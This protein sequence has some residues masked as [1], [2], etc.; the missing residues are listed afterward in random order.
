MAVPATNPKVLT[1]GEKIW[2]HSRRLADNK[3]RGGGIRRCR[4]DQDH[5]E[6]GGMGLL[7]AGEDPN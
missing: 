5:S 3:E 7:W 4:G 1:N 2:G 6:G